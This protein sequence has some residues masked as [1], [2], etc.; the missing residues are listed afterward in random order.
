MNKNYKLIFIHQ[1]RVQLSS[2]SSSIWSLS[3]LHYYHQHWQFGDVGL[4]KNALDVGLVYLLDKD[5]LAKWSSL[6]VYN[7]SCTLWWRSKDWICGNT[8]PKRRNIATLNSVPFASTIITD[9]HWYCKNRTAALTGRCGIST[10]GCPLLP[11]LPIFGCNC[12]VGERA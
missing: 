10:T 5:W 4:L 1:G 8:H 6:H 2:S 11:L 12:G 9:S 7:R 3:L